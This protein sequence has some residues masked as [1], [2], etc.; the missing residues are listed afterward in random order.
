[1]TV[2]SAHVPLGAVRLSPGLFEN[3]RLLNTGY[4]GSLTVP[5]LLQNFYVEAGIGDQSWHLRVA[6]G[7]GPHDGRDRHWGWE[8]PGGLLRGHFLGHWMSAAAREVATGANP[9]LAPAL[10]AVLAGLQRCQRENGGEW[11]FAIPPR[12]LE[13]VAAGLP[14]WAP[15][16]AL[17]KTFMGLVDVYRD[18]G[19]RRALAI[20]D[21]AAAWF[22]RWSEG[23]TPEQFADILDAETGGMLEVWA[24]LLEITGDDRYRRLLDRYWRSRLFDPLLDGVDVLT[25]MH[26]NTTIPEVLGAARA[27]EVTGDER[28][29]RVVEN[30]WRLAVIER[31][32]FC[33]GGQTSGEIW[34]PPFEFA[35]RRGEKTQEHCTVYNMIRLADVLFRWTGEIGYLDYIERNLYNGILAQQNPRTGMVAYFLPLEGG[36]HKHWG[37]PTDDF[38]CCHGTL[39]QAHSR[40]SGLIYYDQPDGAVVVAQLIASRLEL[41][42]FAVTVELRETAVR[43][44]PDANAARAGSRH[45]PDSWGVVITTEATEA[46]RLRVR[47]P[48]WVDGPA[49]A[50][51]G[52]GR[53]E[54]APGFLEIDVDAG[55]TVIELTLPSRLA[56]VPIP[57]EPSTVAFLDGPVVLAGLVDHEVALTGTLPER[58][59]ELLVPDNERQWGEWLR[60]YRTRRQQR[61]IRFRPVYEITDEAFTM[62]FPIAD[63]EG[64][65]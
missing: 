39:V 26:A 51:V 17:H 58:A 1:M 2:P 56:V 35:A 37:T 34:T 41:E 28:W 40:H 27:F 12:F 45:R 42:G 6:E 23:F 24:D 30:Y 36:A 11:V 60:G 8:T 25:N 55:T 15:Q 16:Y 20:A 33:T 57:D 10:D 29:R 44:G 32:T 53:Q 50:Q 5:N 54:V 47:I 62:Y 48:E 64:E 19:D 9:A 61:S 63:A 43:V 18:L 49:I 3:R 22:D 31:G 13:R 59:S 14:T 38:W 46:R 21:A 65:Q 52:D 4:L 7:P